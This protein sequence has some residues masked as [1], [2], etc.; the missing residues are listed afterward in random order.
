MA[1][2]DPRYKYYVYGRKA[3]DIEGDVERKA[4]E[5]FWTTQILK[6]YYYKF[7]LFLRNIIV[8]N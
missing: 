3:E 8:K 5:R 2:K 1:K 6:S 4:G 7:Q